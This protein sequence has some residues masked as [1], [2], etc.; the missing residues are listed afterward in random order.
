MISADVLGERAR[1]TPDA[2][3]LVV[4]EPALRLTYRALDERAARAALALRRLGVAPGERVALLS[5][6]RVEF[7]D[8][9]F[10]AGKG[11]CVLVPL[12]TRLTAHEIAPI[13]AD[14]GA[15]LV[16]YDAEHAA[17]VEAL[18]ALPEA[19]GVELWLPLDAAAGA[20]ATFPALCD[21]ANPRGSRS[22]VLAGRRPALPLS[23]PKSA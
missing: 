3:A 19:S 20:D 22:F 1:L 10:A 11:A 14:S 9:F 4:V 6:N 7:L 23:N 8:L 2:T 21:N 15:R 16:V 17:L 18:R 12:G 13:L 5:H